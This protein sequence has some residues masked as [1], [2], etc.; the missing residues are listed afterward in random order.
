MRIGILG[1]TFDPIHYGH[2]VIAEE[3][4]H[5]LSLDRVILVPAGQPPHKRVRTISPAVHRLAM[6]ELAAADNPHLDISRIELERKGP[7]YSVDTVAQLR[8]ELGPGADLFFIVG[9]DALPDLLTWHA[10][11]RLLQLAVLATVTRPGHEFNLSH[12]VEYIPEAAERIVF[13]PGPSLE[14][15]SSDLRDR[16]SAGLPIRYQVPDAVER[17]VREQGLYR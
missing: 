6:A 2:L 17:Y 7:S 13:V 12:I 15:S 14:I 9:L 4:Y 3:C 16:V 8:E 5:R 11:R 10:P 1:G